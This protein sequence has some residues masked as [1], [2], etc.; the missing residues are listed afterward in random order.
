MEEQPNERQENTHQMAAASSAVGV[1][2]CH[3][4]HLHITSCWGSAPPDRWLM[5]FHPCPLWSGLSCL[6]S[7]AW[8]WFS[9]RITA[10]RSCAHCWQCCTE[11][12]LKSKSH[13]VIIQELLH[14]V[15]APRVLVIVYLRNWIC[16]IPLQL[17]QA[18]FIHHREK[19]SQVHQRELL[20]NALTAIDPASCQ[21]PGVGH[22]VGVPSCCTRCHLTSSEDLYPQH[23]GSHHICLFSQHKQSPRLETVLSSLFHCILWIDHV[24]SEAFEMPT[25]EILIKHLV[26]FKLKNH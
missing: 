6:H 1:P 24:H 16:A 11:S 10:R 23:C 17:S 9:A 7:A 21:V 22:K 20:W 13:L 3:V 14:K 5:R 19:W 8:L 2:R 25:A 18:Y 12:D 15:S 26:L 4:P